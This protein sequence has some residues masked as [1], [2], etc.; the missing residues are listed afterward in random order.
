VAYKRAHVMMIEQ[1]KQAFALAEQRQEQEQQILADL[2]LQEMH[3]EER[4]E[5]LFADP[6]SESLLGRLVAEA[7]VEDE[8]G[9]TEEIID[10]AFL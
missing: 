7:L 8:A 2:L 3:A 5:T 4:W 1:L 10:D 9:E 6:R